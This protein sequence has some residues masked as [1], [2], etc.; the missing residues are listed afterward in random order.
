MDLVAVI[1]SGKGTWG[2]VAH[3]IQDVEWDRIFLLTNEFGKENFACTKPFELMLVDE[4]K[5]IEEMKKDIKA[6]LEG[7]LKPFNEVALNIVSGT[8]KE[9]MA[10][11]AALLELGIGVKFIAL[12]KD[13]VKEL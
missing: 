9:H 13:G 10:L 11:L 2:H 12:T 6:Q 5:G 8:G 3:L 4:R 7:K 1:S